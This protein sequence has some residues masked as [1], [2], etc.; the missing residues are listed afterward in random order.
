[1]SDRNWNFCEKDFALLQAECVRLTEE[2][3]QL[4][5]AYKERGIAMQETGEVVRSAMDQHIKSRESI[6]Q[7]LVDYL[8]YIREETTVAYWPKEMAR[9]ALETYRLW[10]ER[11]MKN[12]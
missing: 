3:E 5:I 11:E 12:K 1:M 10:Y 4:K 9:E 8:Q 7:K 6:I 2:N